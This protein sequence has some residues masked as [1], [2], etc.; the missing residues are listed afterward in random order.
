MVALPATRLLRVRED[1]AEEAR[2]NRADRDVRRGRHVRRRRDRVRQ[3]AAHV[4]V[5]EQAEHAER[6]VLRRR[7]ALRLTRLASGLNFRRTG[8]R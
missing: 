4:V 6:P 8:R 2:D 5:A 7:L 1:R 3:V